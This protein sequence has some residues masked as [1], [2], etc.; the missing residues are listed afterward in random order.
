MSR[1]L[2]PSHT[3]EDGDCKKTKA[4]QNQKLTSVDKEV[5]DVAPQKIKK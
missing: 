5:E 3:Q 1:D 4:K 2:W